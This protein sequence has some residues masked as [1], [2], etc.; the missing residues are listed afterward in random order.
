MS[1]FGRALRK[2]RK[3]RQLSMAELAKVV[4]LSEKSKGYISE[5]ESGKK[6]PSMERLE[7]FADYF[8]VSTDELLGRRRRR[9]GEARG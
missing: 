5:L 7:R 6:R 4:G 1:A 9:D 3:L 2:H 8:G